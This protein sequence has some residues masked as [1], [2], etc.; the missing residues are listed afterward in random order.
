M[1]SLP[2]FQEKDEMLVKEFIRKH[3]FA[4]LIANSQPHPVA[5]Q[6]PLLI[7]EQDSCLLLKGHF[8]RN[9]DHHKALQQDPNVLCVFTGAHSYV[10]ASWYESPGVASTWNYMS[11]HIKGSLQFVADKELIDIL[12]KTTNHYE[13]SEHSPASFAN[14]PQ[15][16][17]QRLS[18]AIVGFE[19]KVLSMDHV[20][21]LSQ[22]RG[23]KDYHNIMV[24][25]EKEGSEAGQ[26]A[27]EMRKRTSQLFHTGE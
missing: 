5:T 27:E 18:K 3:S 21:K 19:I 11:V 14:L 16:Y 15:E 1:Y 20:F 12:Q 6:I 2:S 9:T 23:E 13:G 17:V 8:M 24:Q 26:V 10:S 25:L 7:E 22:N 4:M